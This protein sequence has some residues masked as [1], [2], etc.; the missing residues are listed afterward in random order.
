MSERTRPTPQRRADLPAHWMS[1]PAPGP[2][3][4]T[5]S[6]FDRLLDQ[7]VKEGPARPIDYRL[8]APKWQFL[9]HAADRRGFVLHGTGDPGITCFEP[10]RPADP[11]EFGGRRAVFAAMDGI[12][13]MYF[14]VIDRAGH[15]MTLV[16]ACIRLNEDRDGPYYFF[17][18]TRSALERRPWREGT[19]YLLSADG[20]EPQ[21][22]IA[23]GE[24]EV[25]IAQAANPD[26]VAPVAKLTVRPTDFPFLHQI[27]GHDDQLMKAR[28]MAG[29]VFPWREDD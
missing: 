4:E 27:R 7:A 16:T 2:D 1:R 20:F 28:A 23:F 13:P 12:W 18:I 5:A 11:S 17:S 10:R 19:V 25:R 8:P 6:A 21:P 9:C 14:A 15:A 22:R 3:P 24:T 26:P 29:D